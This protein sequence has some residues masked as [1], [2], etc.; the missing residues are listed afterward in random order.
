M[1]QS[2]P[3]PSQRP[4]PPPQQRPQHQR[5]NS[6]AQQPKLWVPRVS[7][8]LRQAQ[9]SSPYQT[10][11]PQQQQQPPSPRPNSADVSPLTPPPQSPTRDND[12]MPER[13]LPFD[14]PDVILRPTA[15]GAQDPG[16][17]K[18][19]RAAEKQNGEP[20]LEWEVE[21]IKASREKRFRTPQVPGDCS[22]SKFVRWEKDPRANRAASESSS[23]AL[24][25][26]LK[27]MKSMPSKEQKNMGIVSIGSVSQPCLLPCS[28]TPSTLAADY[29]AEAHRA[30]IFEDN[31]SSS[32]SSILGDY[33]TSWPESS[34]YF[35][36]NPETIDEKRELSQPTSTHHSSRRSS[37]E[38]NSLKRQPYVSK[39]VE[40]R[41]VHYAS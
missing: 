40:V 4:V 36:S 12:L 28:V 22:G 23:T 14:E 3:P 31:R 17:I 34:Y 35:S 25:F 32:G 20:L 39:T 18:A 33:I 26:L 29:E 30:V 21:T 2:P 9:L 41:H 15:Y 1:H 11:A 19:L 13:R 7:S 5:K 24:A 38:I 8:P 37:E 6:Q 10:Q 27:S 16:T